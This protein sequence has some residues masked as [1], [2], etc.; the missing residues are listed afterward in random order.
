MEEKLGPSYDL[1]Q[2][3]FRL[4]KQELVDVVSKLS[5]FKRFQV[6]QLY[7]VIDRLQFR[8]FEKNQVIFPVQDYV[9]IIV[10][11]HCAVYD[12]RQNFE[13]P[14]IIAYYTE[15]DIIGCDALGCSA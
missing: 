14:D 15:G 10:A 4:S 8:T 6:K 3:Q 13:M 11:G 5:F 9:Y 1:A 12:H 2:H 7:E